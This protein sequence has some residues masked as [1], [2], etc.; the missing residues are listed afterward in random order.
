MRRA[1]LGLLFF[2]FFF[3]F[4][5]R[6]GKKNKNSKK[7]AHHSPPLHSPLSPPHT[8]TTTTMTQTVPALVLLFGS[9]FL[10]RDTPSSLAGRGLLA[11]GR[12]ELERL[13]GRGGGGGGKRRRRRRKAAAAAAAGAAESE[14]DEDRDGDD[15]SDLERE[16]ETIASAAAEANASAGTAAGG[17]QVENGGSGKGA[18]GSRCSCPS[19]CPSSFSSFLLVLEEDLS[20]LAALFQRRAL[21]ATAVGVGIAAL[22]QVCGINAILFFAAPFFSSL[23]GE[24]TSNSPSSSSSSSI[25]SG[26]LSAVVVGL[27]LFGFTL[28]ALALVDRVGRRL[29]LLAGGAV[30]LATELALAGLLG[31]YLPQS[32]SS[33]SSSSQQQ[34]QL[35]PRGAAAGA[36]FLMCCF[37]AAF[38]SSLGPLGWL[39]PTEVFSAKDR[40]AGQALATAVN[41]LFVF[42]TTQFFLASLCA[43][44]HW[45]FVAAASAVVVLLLFAQFLMP[46]GERREIRE[47]VFFSVGKGGSRVVRREEKKKNSTLDHKIKNGKKNEKTGDQGRAHRSRPGTVEGPPGLV[48]VRYRRR[49][50]SWRGGGGGWRERR[51][52]KKRGGGGA[53]GSQKKRGRGRKGSSSAAEEGERRLKKKRESFFSLS[54]SLFSTTLI[55]EH[56]L[57]VP[58]GLFNL[59]LGRLLTSGNEIKKRR[60]HDGKRTKT[61]EKWYF[62]S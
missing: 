28:V 48:E 58:G 59:L 6:R 8:T 23:T 47:R 5:F 46:V 50:L 62:F 43:M 12:A 26:L 55:V 10:L 20:S 4:F 17:A 39:V 57:S 33:S 13:R 38:A 40:S 52:R 7:A 15:S 44:R 29:L 41:F 25:S 3:C 36:L 27:A 42:V 2:P 53:R 9:L 49:S 54:L 56:L 32:S 14:R 60:K 45:T 51:R 30:M 61:T 19:C 37:V 21:P 1:E 31:F 16:W 11:E 18:S 22:S 34:Q 24:G 35:L